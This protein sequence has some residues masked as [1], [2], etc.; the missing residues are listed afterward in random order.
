MSKSDRSLLEV[1]MEGGEAIVDL[2]TTN[3]AVREVPVV[4]TAFKVLKGLDD[5]RSR[6]LQTKL[7]KFVSEPSLVRSMAAGRIRTRLQ[8]DEQRQ[9]IGEGLFLTLEKVTDLQK[10]ELLGRVFAAYL[11]EVV[12]GDTL[13]LL[14][15]AIDSAFARDLHYF[16][17]QHVDN[18]LERN[19]IVLRLLSTGLVDYLEFQATPLGIALKRVATH[20]QQDSEPL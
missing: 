6:I 12:D 7:L 20:T 14:A 2:F 16:L 5:L 15:H 1:V 4:G 19:P 11:D 9:Q 18:G 8:D 17:V 3:E 13:L 10:P